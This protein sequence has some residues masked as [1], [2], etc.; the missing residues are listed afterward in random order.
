MATSRKGAQQVRDDYQA[1]WSNMQQAQRQTDDTEV[2]AVCD[3]LLE[4]LALRVRYLP[5][6]MGVPGAD[7]GADRT[8]S[9]EQPFEPPPCMPPTAQTPEPDKAAT[10]TPCT[11]LRGWQGLLNPNPKATLTLTLTLTP[12]D[13]KT[14]CHE[15]RGGV[16]RVWE[17]EAA[18][19]AAEPAFEPPPTIEAFTRDL[20][21]LIQI[22]GDAAVNSFCHRRLQ[23]LQARF[24]LHLM[25]NGHHESAEQRACPHRDFYNIRKVS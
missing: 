15:M 5:G 4:A 16:M 3:Q 10:H 11:L 17:P 12:G 18:V 2:R 13:G 21:R 6:P 8:R 24:Q 9:A 19:A 23:K 20:S 14:Y 7:G 25:D 1:L 22:C